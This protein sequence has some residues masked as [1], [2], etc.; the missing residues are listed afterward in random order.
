MYMAYQ[1]IVLFI[2]NGQVRI[3]T[4]NFASYPDC[5]AAENSVMQTPDPTRK[6]IQCSKPGYRI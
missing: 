5:L 2:V 3:E 6:L 4:Q 1:L